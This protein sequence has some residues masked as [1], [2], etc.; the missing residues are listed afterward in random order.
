MR[1]R[2]S[3]KTLQRRLKEQQMCRSYALTDDVYCDPPA[4]HVGGLVTAVGVLQLVVALVFS[5]FVFG[6]TLFFCAVLLA[7]V[8]VTLLHH[9]DGKASKQ[10]LGLKQVMNRLLTLHRSA[11][12]YS[13][14][15]SIA[16][17]DEYKQTDSS[18]ELQIAVVPSSFAPQ[19]VVATM[20]LKDDEA[21]RIQEDRKTKLCTDISPLV[22]LNRVH[23]LPLSTISSLLVKTTEALIMEKPRANS[24]PKQVLRSR[25]LLPLKA[26]G[27]NLDPVQEKTTQAGPTS[28]VLRT[29]AKQEKKTT[30][31]QAKANTTRSQQKKAAPKAPTVSATKQSQLPAVLPKIEP[32]V[33]IP[34][35]LPTAK[36]VSP[37]TTANVE[38]VTSAVAPLPVF[39]KHKTLIEVVNGE[40]AIER[41]VVVTRK[42]LLY[43]NP[44][45]GTVVNLD[46]QDHLEHE[47]ECKQDVER[48]H[49]PEDFALS[50]EEFPPLSPPMVPQVSTSPPT[51][52]VVEPNF[53]MDI[54]LEPISKSEK[55]LI[56]QSSLYL[57][58]VGNA[59]LRSMMDEL[60]TM[61]FELDAALACCTSLH[62][63]VE[64]VSALT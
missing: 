12:D 13:L 20:T 6:G 37:T 44:N 30:L 3:T 64:K 43:L 9:S 36:T 50:L 45:V 24:E 62:H 19:K 51:A 46:E 57:E 63:E 32:G 53:L 11:L 5:G 17:S 18:K 54:E 14:T 28:A 4:F 1:Q 39:P 52:H 48:E 25:S 56:S 16:Q 35:V 10:G 15:L 29:L 38:H 23:L 40:A 58:S 27:Q 61:R 55:K 59:D 34:A 42:V 41:D 31:V 47:A 49:E 8:G 33:A 21:L 2:P 7:T 60:D 22:T 26:K